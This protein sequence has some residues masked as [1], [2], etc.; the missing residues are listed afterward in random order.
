M[1]QIRKNVFETNSSSTHSLTL[2]SEDEFEKWK[3]GE[4][5]FDR[6]KE[7]FVESNS[8]SDEDKLRAKM[9]Y[10]DTKGE[11]WKDW[12]FLSDDAKN[13]WYSKWIKKYREHEDYA[14]YN[15]YMNEG[16]L[17]CFVDRYTSK[18]GDKIVAFGKYGYDG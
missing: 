7:V 13:T 18:S 12:E 3:K 8:I 10:D 11:Y 4:L 6:W 15:E 9:A 2:C 16:Y 5:L 14:T 1:K 17:E